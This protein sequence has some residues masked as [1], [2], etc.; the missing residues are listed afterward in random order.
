MRTSG[1]TSGGSVRWFGSRVFGLMVAVVYWGVMFSVVIALAL[2][3]MGWDIRLPHW[4][5]CPD[6]RPPGG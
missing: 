5:T 4:A 6:C 2:I 1:R 3:V